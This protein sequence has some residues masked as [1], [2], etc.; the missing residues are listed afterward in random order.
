MKNYFKL[1][2]VFVVLASTSLTSVA[3]AG[4]I[5][6]YDTNNDRNPE[7]WEGLP[8][9]KGTLLINGAYQPL[10]NTAQPRY[11]AY[12]V[13]RHGT[14][15]PGLYDL[16]TNKVLVEKYCS[17]SVWIWW[18][19]PTVLRYEC[20]HGNDGSPQNIRGRLDVRDFN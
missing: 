2:L 11:L 8:T 14:Y 10:R 16:R 13:Q 3:L 7:I 19:S 15:G 17:P 6:V 18:I 4:R 20:A 9:Q 5:G 1:V 12:V